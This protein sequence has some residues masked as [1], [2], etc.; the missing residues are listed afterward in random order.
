MMHD[1]G[2]KEMGKVKIIWSFMADNFFLP[3][4]NYMSWK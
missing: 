1:M 2:N 3:G 4:E